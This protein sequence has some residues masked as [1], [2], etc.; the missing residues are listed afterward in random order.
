MSFSK[1]TKYLFGRLLGKIFEDEL[2]DPFAK[3]P[4]VGLSTGT[5]LHIV[6][7]IGIQSPNIH[8][9]KELNHTAKDRKTNKLQRCVS[10]T[11]L[12]GM[13]HLAF[14]EGDRTY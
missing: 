1:Y 11:F 7:N 3:C 5:T 2:L 10:D 12:L 8:I 9:G 14:R 13:V 6:D 4:S